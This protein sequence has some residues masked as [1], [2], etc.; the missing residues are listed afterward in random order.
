MREA[1]HP[2]QQSRTHLQECTEQLREGSS[3]HRLSTLKQQ[4]HLPS[5]PLHDELSRN[6]MMAMV[7]AT[8][9]RSLSELFLILLKKGNCF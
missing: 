4:Q 2:M 8:I 7:K 6:L 5:P 9:R 3:V 1:S